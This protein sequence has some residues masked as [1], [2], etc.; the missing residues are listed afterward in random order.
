MNTIK[1]KL[2][3]LPTSGRSLTNIQKTN[4]NLG[5]VVDA[6]PVSSN[7]EFVEVKGFRFRVATETENTNIP[8]QF[9]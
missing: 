3:Q 1:V 2:V 7:H 6:R 8:F 4:L 9:I 5:D